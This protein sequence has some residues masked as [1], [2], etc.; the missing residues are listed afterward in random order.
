MASDWQQNG[1]VLSTG[2][3]TFEVYSDVWGVI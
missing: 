3:W 1:I 2:K